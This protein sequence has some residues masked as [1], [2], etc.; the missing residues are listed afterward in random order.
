VLWFLFFVANAFAVLRSPY[1]QK[2]DPPSRTIIITDHSFDK[3]VG[4]ARKPK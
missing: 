1:P 3:T 2:A 4:T